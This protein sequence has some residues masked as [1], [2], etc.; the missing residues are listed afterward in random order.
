[1]QDPPDAGDLQAL[2]DRGQTLLERMEYLAAEA[3]LVEAD[4]LA[5]ERG[6]FD[7]LARLYMP[8][9]EARRQRRQRCGEGTVRLDLWAEGPND[10]IVARHVA[11]NYPHGQLLIAGWASVA[12]A[13]AFRKLAA[14][15]ALYA[16]TYLAAVYPVGDGRL[17]VIVP[18]A[19]VALPPADAAADGNVD[20]LLRKLPPHSLAFSEDEF[21][22]G[23]A[24]GTDATFART[25]ALWETLHA[26]FLAAADAASTP[27]RKIAGYRETI[28]VDYAAEK[29]HQRLS[30]AACELA[31][32]SK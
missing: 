27:A 3:V 19:D 6:D 32:T 8:L 10:E 15:H 16:E 24:A 17:L 18:T 5:T 1:M 11:Q 21:P 12:P 14:Q 20:A 28:A 30:V 26:P 9:Q 13:V 22:R 7:T 31:R 23:A 4:H 2:C 25:M 29:A